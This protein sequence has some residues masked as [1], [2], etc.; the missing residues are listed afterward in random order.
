MATWTYIEESYHF[1]IVFC[2]CYLKGM[3]LLLESCSLAILP[4]GVIM[5]NFHVIQTI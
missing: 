4:P 1:M 5:C 3:M 2:S